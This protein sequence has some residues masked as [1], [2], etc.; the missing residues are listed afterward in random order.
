[1]FALG[2]NGV[3]MLRPSEQTV[4]RRFLVGS[5]IL[6]CD[7]IVTTCISPASP[8]DWSQYLPG[9]SVVKYAQNRSNTAYVEGLVEYVRWQG[10]P[11]EQNGV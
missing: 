10:I 4:E 3:L 1:M 9:R 2:E 8:N 7:Q 11:S 5:N 6:D